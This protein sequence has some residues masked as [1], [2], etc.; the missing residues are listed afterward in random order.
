MTTKKTSDRAEGYG[1]LV[2]LAVVCAVVYWAYTGID[3]IGWMEH[4][5]DSVIT[6]Q[7]NWF[8]GESKDCTSYPLDAKTAQALNKP[9]GYSVSQ[10]NCDGGPEHQVKI[11]F[12]GRTEQPEY[13]WITWRC[14]R[15]DGSFTCKQIAN[16]SPHLTGK[17]VKTGRPIVS[18]D[19][20]KTWQWADQ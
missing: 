8:I 3:S 20:G 7:A 12:F 2:L 15:N 9:K 10:I 13:D 17:N 19:G 16:S 4:R 6:A 5:E 14:T 1:C 18:E 11:S